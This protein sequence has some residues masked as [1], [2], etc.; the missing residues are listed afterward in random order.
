MP[1]QHESSRRSVKAAMGRELGDAIRGTPGHQVRQK[2]GELT[3]VRP[4]SMGQKSGE[5][6]NVRPADRDAAESERGGAR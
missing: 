5:L 3:N 2:S 4:A 1:R 6:T